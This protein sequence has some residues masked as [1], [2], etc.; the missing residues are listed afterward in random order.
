MREPVITAPISADLALPYFST[1]PNSSAS[2]ARVDGWRQAR[3]AFAVRR[4]P[5]GH[6]Q[7]G[8]RCWKT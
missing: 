2:P 8:P 7:G 4:A 5:P 1:T 6:R 3:L